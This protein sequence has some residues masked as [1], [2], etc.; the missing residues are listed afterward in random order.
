M[1]IA[2]GTV[3]IPLGVLLLAFGGVPKQAGED[4]AS[5]VRRVAKDLVF[6]WGMGLMT[7]SFG[8]GLVF[9]RVHFG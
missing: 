8:L 3:L 6:R 9:E 1:D 5:R 2:A 4:A 7:L